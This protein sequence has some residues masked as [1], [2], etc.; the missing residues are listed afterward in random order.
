MSDI[1]DQ[2]EDVRSGRGKR[3]SGGASMR[4]TRDPRLSQLL[5]WVW[6]ALGG[7]A[8]L[9]GVGM[10]NKLSNMNDTLLVAVSKLE[11]QGSQI[12]DLRYDMAKLR[13]ENASLKTQIAVVQGK[14]E[15]GIKEFISGH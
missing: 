6:T 7:L 2:H 3:E 4:D 11:A 15:R 9:I 10:Y 13:E 8:L 5:S 12:N 1:D 14:M